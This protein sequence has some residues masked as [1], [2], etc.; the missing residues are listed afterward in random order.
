MLL[1][2]MELMQ[3]LFIEAEKGNIEVFETLVSRWTNKKAI[4]KPF[5]ASANFILL[6]EFDDNRYFL[7]FNEEKIKSAEEVKA[8]LDY[9][10]FIKSKGM[11]AINPVLSLNGNY[12]ETLKIDNRMLNA[13][14]FKEIEGKQLDYK[15]LSIDHFK[16]WGESMGRIHRISSCYPYDGRRKDWQTLL[17]DAVNLVSEDDEEFRTACE[18]IRQQLSEIPKN[19]TSYGLIHFDMELDNMIWKDSEIYTIDFDDCSYHWF[20]ADIA[21]ALRD[22]FDEGHNI[23]VENENF[24]AFIEGYRSNHSFD[25]E[26][27]VWLPIMY[28]FHR[29]LQYAHIFYA[30]KN[31]DATNDTS[32]RKKLRERHEGY[33]AKLRKDLLRDRLK[34]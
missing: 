9:L 3:S 34:K 24:K 19:Q 30:Y 15:Q 5:R 18:G 6:V 25:E 21:Y 13:V 23:D 26:W 29:L 4:I 14:M 1:M 11:K 27:L 12:M 8:E 33:L 7:R 22:I 31:T 10:N 16:L 20:V 17:N 2:D 32:W 28:E